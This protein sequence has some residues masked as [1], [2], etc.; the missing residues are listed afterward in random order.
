MSSSIFFIRSIRLFAALLCT[1]S[2]MAH[3]Q[4]ANVFKTDAKKSAIVLAPNAEDE[5]VVRKR[6]VAVNMPLFQSTERRLKSNAIDTVLRFNF[7]DDAPILVKIDRSESISVGEK[8]GVAYYGSVPG[9]PFSSATIVEINGVIAGNVRALSQ[10]YQIRYRE[11]TGHEVREVDASVFRDHDRATYANFQRKEEARQKGD[12]GYQL[13]IVTPQ[14]KA[15]RIKNSPTTQR[16]DGSTIDVMVVYTPQAL[17]AAGGLAGMESRIAL[18]GTE[19][20]ETYAN[21]NV[22]QRVRIVFS[23]VVSFNDTGNI[24]DDLTKLRST[25]D[26][27]LDEVHPLRDAY[28]ADAVSLWVSNAGNLC[29]IGYLMSTESS[30]FAGSAFNVVALSCATGNLTFGH[31]LGHNMGLRHDLF[32]DTGTNTLTPEN[33]TVAVSGVN[34]AHGYIDTVNR[35]R[36]NMAYT[37][38]CTAAGVSCPKIKNFSNPDVTR[39][40]APTGVAATANNARALNDTRET[41][42]N[43]RQTV[44]SPGGGVITFLPTS[45]S[46]IEGGSVTITV[47]RLAGSIGAAS[48]D[49]ATVAG[50]ATTGD[51]TPVSGT[52]RWADGE[53]GSKTITIQTLQDTL[54]EGDER[55]SVTLTNPSGVVLSAATATILIRDDEIGVFPPNCVMPTGTSTAGWSTPDGAT[56]GWQVGFDS[57]SE[58]SCSLK[59]ISPGDSPADTFTRRSQIQF[60]GNFNAGNIT[61][62][63]RVS[64]ELNWDCLRFSIDG[65]TQNIGST[66]TGARGLGASGEA[67]WSSL[68]FPI[69][70]GQ[71]TLLWSYEKDDSV[72]VGEDAAWID[73]LVM[74][75]AAAVP[76]VPLAPLTVT[77]T[78]A[79]QG[80]VTSQP[81][82]IA[83]GATCNALLN[84]GSTVTL[85]AQAAAGSVFA[86][87]TN[88]QGLT[89]CV[90]LSTCTF[91]LTQATTVTAN[92]QLAT[93]GLRN[94]TLVTLAASASPSAAGASFNLVAAVTGGGGIST[95]AAITGTLSF[96][97]LTANG[98]VTVCSA[99]P[100]VTTANTFGATCAVPLA[101]RS[102][103]VQLYQVT[104][105]GDSNFAPA[106]ST[107]RQVVGGANNQTGLSISASPVKPMVGQTVTITVLANGASTTP[108]GSVQV[109]PPAGATSTC[110]TNSLAALPGTTSSAIA[111]CTI[112]GIQAGSVNIAASYAGDTNNAANTASM[113]LPIVAAG[114]LDYTDM[115]WAGAAENGWG[116]SISQHGATQFNALYVY[117]ATGKPVWYVMPGGSW[118][119]TFTTYSGAIYQ[120]TSAPFFNYNTSQFVVGA[121]PGTVSINFTS[122]NTATLNYTINGFSGQKNITRQPF[123]ATTTEALPR[124][125]VNDL[126]WAGSDENG[127]GI[128]IA[129]SGRTLFAVWY[130]YGADG[131]ATWYVIPGGTWN[132][133][134]FSGEAY[135]TTGSPW[136]GA[137]YDAARLVI[138][139]VGNVTITFLDSNMAL[140][141]YTISGVSQTKVIYRQPY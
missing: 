34:Y 104:Y 28:G 5:G 141:R 110:A 126:W 49:F 33:S 92:F 109:T 9:V 86:G 39:N 131:K 80:S 128:N 57:A 20:N 10:Q 65:V 45:Y 116:M 83:C 21:S 94:S 97:Q 95:A 117:D 26:G 135:A 139:A 96:A 51:F 122:A 101:N 105:A 107:L 12:V 64:S 90:G 58:G 93:A 36:T 89:N 112:A 88:N 81:A 42:A 61:F 140:M 127:W 53:S 43:F 71:H 66:C 41:V 2:L 4:I 85:T 63:R 78:G 18:A 99:V 119:S 59:S 120:P 69:T 108:T 77:R 44:I 82:G 114:P 37:D 8:T 7:F 118:N 138:N 1:T 47:Q 91:T 121:S 98:A 84:G 137:T 6:A 16:D 106:I 100:I 19:T 32:V 79:G 23:A 38:G 50:T 31:E 22:K 73:K 35:F 40:G 133:A 17:A 30:G 68:S 76:P 11:D 13:G 67:A 24:S 102:N 25:T 124:L 134:V 70:A 87:W 27:I 29:G 56:T 3:A 111:V 129:Q 132:G 123:G 74:P 54:V 103:G 15:A 125:I 60:V 46:V 130:T 62:D 14:V 75:L 115:W 55:F 52:L 113:M 72:A 48:V 136:V